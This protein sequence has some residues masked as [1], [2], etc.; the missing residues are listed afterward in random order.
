M[1]PNV[2]YMDMP[3]RVRGLT[4]KNSDGTYT[5]ILNSRLSYEQNLKTYMHELKHIK[6]NDFDKPDIED[7][8]RRDKFGI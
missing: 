7:V 3:C 5:I 6:N 1:T 4:H 8:E 2:H